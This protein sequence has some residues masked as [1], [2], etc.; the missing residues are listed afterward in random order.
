MGVTERTGVIPE[1][2]LSMV[3]LRAVLLPLAN[4]IWPLERLLRLC[5]N[6][7][8]GL[9]LAQIALR[10]GCG[11]NAIVGKV[12]RLIDKN[13]LVGR[14]QPGGGWSSGRAARDPKEGAEALRKARAASRRESGS[15]TG[16]QEGAAQLAHALK[17]TGHPRPAPLTPPALVV[18]PAPVPAPKRLIPL[19]LNKPLAPIP[20]TV[21][22]SLAH[23]TK[24]LAT[25]R[26]SPRVPKIPE[27]IA[28][29]P[30]AP[31]IPKYGRVIECC[32]PTGHPGTP[33]FRMCDDPS[34]PGR[35][36]CGTHTKKAYVKIRDLR[37]HPQTL[38][39]TGAFL[40]GAVR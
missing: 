38:A 25:S 34:E 15:T 14:G 23:A 6:Y 35:P 18:P 10:F 29:I 28:R 8:E 30:A 9:S 11:K 21:R 22:P 24:A 1:P 5:L 39:G 17:V 13:I 26:N 16:R 33:A 20:A 32:W 7:R 36:Y 19:A 4:S 12:H 31:L 3:E 40:A 2:D 37:E 27:P